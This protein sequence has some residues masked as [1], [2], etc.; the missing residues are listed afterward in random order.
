M[1]FGMG[2]K[3]FLKI[4]LDLSLKII[5]LLFCRQRLCFLLLKIIPHQNDGGFFMYL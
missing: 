2:L 1:I 3:S 5:V 4:Y